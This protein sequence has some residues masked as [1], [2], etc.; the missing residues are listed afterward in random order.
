MQSS[1]SLI[2]DCWV[3]R[4]VL[5]HPWAP[6]NVIFSISL[7][8][9]LCVFSNTGLTVCV[10][11]DICTHTPMRF[12]YQ[13]HRTCAPTHPPGDLW[14]FVC[15]SVCINVNSVL[16]LRDSEGLE[17]SGWRWEV[18]SPPLDLWMPACLPWQVAPK[19]P[20]PVRCWNRP[21]PYCTSA[22]S[23]T[24]RTGSSNHRLNGHTVENT[25][26]HEWSGHSL[27]DALKE[28]RESESQ[29]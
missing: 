11:A 18:V 15:V 1:T 16:P 19:G 20:T 29:W 7:Y 14:V 8:K 25:S 2:T 17:E 24:Y 12:L 27:N 4:H 9:S 23:G 13:G 28:R 21:G 6:V 22:G 5:K 3:C 26:A 10:S